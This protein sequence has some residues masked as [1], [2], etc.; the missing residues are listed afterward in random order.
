M[1]TNVYRE[2][3]IYMNFNLNYEGFE[4]YLLKRTDL[5]DLRN[6]VHYLFKFPNNRGA[7]VVKYAGSYGYSKDLWELGVVLFGT[8]DDIWDLD[9]ETEITC[10]VIGCLT[11]DGVRDLL[12]RIKELDPI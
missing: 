3:S 4:D 12:K 6:G 10:D 9:Y 1:K 7:S 5:I 11:D 2:R 8:S